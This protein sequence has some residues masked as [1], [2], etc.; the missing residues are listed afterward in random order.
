[1]LQIPRYG[2]AEAIGKSSGG[3]ADARAEGRKTDFHE[4]N[5][6]AVRIWGQIE[7]NV[8]IKTR[9]KTRDEGAAQEVAATFSE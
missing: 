8:A 7:A 2:A 4:T 6:C 1:V 5:G 3:F 9:D